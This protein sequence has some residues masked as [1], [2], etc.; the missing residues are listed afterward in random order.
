MAELAVIVTAAKQAR[1]MEKRPFE[2]P[3]QQWIRAAVLRPGQQSGTRMYARVTA[4]RSKRQTRSAPRAGAGV[5]T[6]AIVA[7]ALTWRRTGLLKTAASGMPSAGTGATT[8]P[9][10]R[11][12][13]V[14]QP[15]I[16]RLAQARGTSKP[17]MTAAAVGS[18]A[19]AMPP[20]TT[21]SQVTARRALPA[22]C[23]A[24]RPVLLL[25]RT[26]GI[27]ATAGTVSAAPVATSTMLVNVEKSAA[28]RA[29]TNHM[30]LVAAETRLTAGNVLT[31]KTVRHGQSLVPSVRATTVGR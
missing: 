9:G 2:L 31:A 17:R 20:A 3:L 29:A 21:R 1:K 8:L 24:A 6:G 26:R 27:A 4:V 30:R 10:R 7:A 5:A 23:S 13:H 14:H 25:A 15:P 18:Q 28:R 22:G 11:T 12:P 19:A 16:S